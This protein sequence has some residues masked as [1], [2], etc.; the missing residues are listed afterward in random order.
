MTDDIK[1]ER[2]EWNPGKAIHTVPGDFG[3]Q[4]IVED[5]DYNG[6]PLEPPHLTV[7]LPHQC[8][9]WDISWQSKSKEEAVKDLQTFIEEAQ[10]AIRAI[11]SAPSVQEKNA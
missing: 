9:P 6:N 7:A 1:F 8:D 2:E 11:E 10:L 4:V 5:L 3:F